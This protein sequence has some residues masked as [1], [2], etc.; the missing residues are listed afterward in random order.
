MK[1]QSSA[2][3]DSSASALTNDACSNSKRDSDNGSTKST[4]QTNIG[5]ASRPRHGQHNQQQHRRNGNNR[6]NQNK[7][8]GN[9]GGFLGDTKDMN[10][11]VFQVHAEQTK[12]GQFQETLDMLKIYASTAYKK[13]ITALNPLFSKLTEPRVPEPEEPK[14][15]IIKT[16]GGKEI[17]GITKFSETVYNERVKMYIKETK[18]LQSTVQSLY[19]IV[20]GQCS[21]LMKNKVHA[22]K[23]F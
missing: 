17:C 15:V 14:E 19:N 11:H 6:Q 9:G 8:A 22:A 4:R 13:D 16:E 3:S 12:R 1:N 18:S 10:G 5:R 20:W 21:K 2:A 7:Q 23:D